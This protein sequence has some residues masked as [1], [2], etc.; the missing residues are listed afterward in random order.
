MYLHS[1]YIVL[2]SVFSSPWG[3]VPADKLLPRC[4]YGQQSCFVRSNFLT[5]KSHRRSQDGS[6]IQRGF[7]MQTQL[8]GFTLKQSLMTLKQ[9]LGHTL[10]M[11]TQQL[12]SSPLL[13]CQS[14]L[15]WLIHLFIFKNNTQ[16][17]S[18]IWAKL[19]CSFLNGLMPNYAS[20][21]L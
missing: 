4:A 8:S 1:N 3:L 9:M 13:G 5:G 11:M 14:L 15:I 6:W 17:Q 10:S 12:H 16:R 20:L 21:T 2:G 7:V 18:T 19:I